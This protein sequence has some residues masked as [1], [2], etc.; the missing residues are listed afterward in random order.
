[1]AAT[2]S[3]PSYESYL[4]EERPVDF[5]NPEPA[6]LE[7][8]PLATALDGAPVLIASVKNLV[9]EQRQAVSPVQ[10][11]EAASLEEDGASAESR[12]ADFRK[13]VVLS[14]LKPRH[15]K[16]EGGNKPQVPPVTRD[17]KEEKIYFS[18]LEAAKMLYSSACEDGG[19]LATKFVDQKKKK[20]GSEK[21][22]GTT[23]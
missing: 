9:N 21:S 23:R 6:G 12:D 19:Y 7:D 15:F 16:L 4:D 17:S 14:Q 1:M 5:D 20:T 8:T 10:E 11:E 13:C 22:S 2:K 18:S 3:L